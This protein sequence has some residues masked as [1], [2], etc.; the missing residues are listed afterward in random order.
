MVID[1]G[2][3]TKF[4]TSGSGQELRHSKNFFATSA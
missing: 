4:P 2:I 3:L 1:A